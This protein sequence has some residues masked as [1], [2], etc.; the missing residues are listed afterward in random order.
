MGSVAPGHDNVHQR[1]GLISNART[2]HWDRAGAKAASAHVWCQATQ[3][4]CGRRP[5]LVACTIPAV[6]ALQSSPL[7]ATRSDTAGKSL[8]PPARRRSKRL[9]KKLRIEEFKEYGFA[10]SFRLSESLSPKAADDFW[11]AFLVELIERR[12][13]AFGG[14]E[15]G[16]VTKFGRGSA[17]E[18]DREAALKWLNERSGVERVAVGALED[19]WYGHPEPAA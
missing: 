6:S 2:V 7:M 16:Y 13:L 12:G 15:E 10:V 1:P 11:S 19:A 3:A 17:T 4:A 14:G 18:E 9:R 8:P 5:H